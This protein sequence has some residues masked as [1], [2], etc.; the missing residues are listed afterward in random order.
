MLAWIPGSDEDSS[1]FY[2]ECFDVLVQA[3]SP[4]ATSAEIARLASALGEAPDTPPFTGTA[5]A[6]SGGLDY[7]AFTLPYTGEVGPL[8]VSAIEIS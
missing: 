8:T 5:D 2:W 1:A 7:R 3:V 6:S 4:G